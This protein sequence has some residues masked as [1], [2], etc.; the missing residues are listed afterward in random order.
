VVRT[1]AAVEAGDT[2][3]STDAAVLCV[4]TV[5][6]YRHDAD[7]LV[8]AALRRVGGHKRPPTPDKRWLQ[9]IP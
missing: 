3:A 4:S 7:L 1:D 6:G 2:L 8:L 5:S 9:G